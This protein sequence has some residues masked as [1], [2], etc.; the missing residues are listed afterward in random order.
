MLDY[1]DS[2][3]LSE[4]SLDSLRRSQAFF[5]ILEVWPFFLLLPVSMETGPGSWAQQHIWGSDG[6]TQTQN[7]YTLHTLTCTQP[8]AMTLSIWISFMRESIFVILTVRWY[9]THACS[10][11]KNV[12]LTEDPPRLDMMWLDVRLRKIHTLLPRLHPPPF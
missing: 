9:V 10:P 12:F 11:T 7:I 1:K 2:A 4:H 5:L 8:H 3:T 6:N